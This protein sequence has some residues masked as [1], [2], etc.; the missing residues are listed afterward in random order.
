MNLKVDQ[1]IDYGTHNSE[2]VLLSVTG[3]CSL[4]YYLL[5]DTTYTDDT[6]ISNKLRHFY[7]FPAQEVK[8]GDKIILY[9]KPGTNSNRKLPNGNTEYTYYWGLGNSV[10]NNTGDAAILFHIDNWKTTKVK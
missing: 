10:W 8:V 1:I 6:H 4:H 5:A 3:D 9:T 7:W 2:R